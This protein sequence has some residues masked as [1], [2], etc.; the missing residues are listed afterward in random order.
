MKRRI[1]KGLGSLGLVTGVLALALPFSGA[2]VRADGEKPPTAAVKEGA[3]SAKMKASLTL[4]SLGCLAVT[5][6][7]I[8]GLFENP[9][10]IYLIVES[11]RAGER[12]SSA[13]L[14]D[15]GAHWDI[16]YYGSIDNVQVWS[17]ELAEGES[18]AVWVRAMEED[19][20]AAATIQREGKPPTVLVN[21][22]DIVGAVAAVLT[23]QKGKL[24]VQWV[25]G[26][27]AQPRPF[28]TVVGDRR[29]PDKKVMEWWLKGDGSWY[30][31]YFRTDPVFE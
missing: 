6:N 28:T 16:K 3:L 15:V 9:D 29:Y 14:P 22:D 24:V 8:F 21:N 27:S 10:E 19:R 2:P 23:N 26:E 5:D 25:T 12:L 4:L 30:L 7:G 11:W 17:G 1:N 18:I 20:G 13:R 31:A